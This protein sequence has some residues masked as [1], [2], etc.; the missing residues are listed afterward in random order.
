VRQQHQADAGG[1]QGKPP[2]DPVHHPARAA[3]RQPFDQDCL[4]AVADGEQNVLAGRVMQVLEVRKRRRPQPVPTRRQ[5]GDLKQP[6]PDHVLAVSRLLKRAP[7]HQLAGQAQR[8]RLRQAGP[9]AQRRQR[10]RAVR[11]PECRHDPERPV[12]DRLAA[13]GLAPARRAAALHVSASCP[14]GRFSQ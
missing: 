12:Q 8:G 11:R 9:G 7:L 13:S 10:E 6:Q 2:A 1:V 4:L 3:G 14:P 5:R